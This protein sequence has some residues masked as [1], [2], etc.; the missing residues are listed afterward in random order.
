MKRAN[1]KDKSHINRIHINYLRELNYLNDWLKYRNPKKM[2]NR[3]TEL[4]DENKFIKLAPD[5]IKDKLGEHLNEKVEIIKEA[6]DRKLY[7]KIVFDNFIKMIKPEFK[8]NNTIIKQIDET[9]K[10]HD[11]FYNDLKKAK[12]IIA[13]I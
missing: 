13:K 9:I 7:N 10:L 1:N 2:T 11:Q 3:A 4:I 12:S 5:D 6:I 8:D